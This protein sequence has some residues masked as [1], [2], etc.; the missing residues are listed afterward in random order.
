MGRL[1]DLMAPATFVTMAASIG[2][3][4]PLQAICD[5]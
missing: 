3:K 2:K 5:L 1:S 4:T